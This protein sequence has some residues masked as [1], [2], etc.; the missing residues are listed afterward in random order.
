MLKI[1]RFSLLLLFLLLTFTL[2]G[3]QKNIDEN[4][5]PENTLLAQNDFA[6]YYFFYPD[7][8]TLD[9]NTTFISIIKSDSLITPANRSISVMESDLVDA[10]MSLTDF[11]AQSKKLVN[12][13]FKEFTEVST[14]EIKVAELDALT[15]V[16]TTKTTDKVYKFKQ[17]FIKNGGKVYIITYTATEADFDKSN[18][19]YNT[20]L[21]TFKFR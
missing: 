1:K 4:A 2:F 17:T 21:Q 14:E 16:Y 12:E 19:A 15:A 13:T 5:G 11:W 7:D 18:D 10:K 20:V 8:W 6:N 9:S 3:C